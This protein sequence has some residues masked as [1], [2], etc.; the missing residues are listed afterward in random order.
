[1]G[2]AA[3]GHFAGFGDRWLEY[4]D[5]PLMSGCYADYLLK[6]LA[7]NRGYRMLLKWHLPQRTPIEYTTEFFHTSYCSQICKAVQGRLRA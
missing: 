2:S 3:E 6:G 7:L 5:R 1:M 4:L